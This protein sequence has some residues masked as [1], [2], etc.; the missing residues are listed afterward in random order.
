MRRSR[1]RLGRKHNTSALTATGVAQDRSAI[2]AQLK[3]AGEPMLRVFGPKPP[4]ALQRRLEI[5]GSDWSEVET[6]TLHA[7]SGV[8]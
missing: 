2:D 1:R 4:Y 3:T 5:H 7:I 6:P 8:E